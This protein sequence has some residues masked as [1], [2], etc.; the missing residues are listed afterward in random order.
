MYTNVKG[1]G[2]DYLCVLPL[3]LPLDVEVED[4]IVDEVVLG[5]APDEVHVVAILKW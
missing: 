1:D 2:L 5:G 4:H 3:L